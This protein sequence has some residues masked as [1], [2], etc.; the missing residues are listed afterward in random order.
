LV[1]ELRADAFERAHP[2]LQA[3]FSHYALV[4]IHPFADGNGRVARALASIYLYREAS[5]PF[6]LFAD[7]ADSYLAALRAADVGRPQVFVDFV[8]DRAIG[9]M[10]RFGDVIRF[11]DV[12]PAEQ[13]LKAIE[14][15]AYAMPGL[16][17]RQLDEAARRL[18][19]FVRAELQRQA[20]ALPKP[21]T[22]SIIFHELG[23]ARNA[24]AGFRAPIEPTF[25]GVRLQMTNKAP[26]EAAVYRD[27]HI[28]VTTGQQRR[29]SFV[30]QRDKSEETLM[31]GVDDVHPDISLDAQFRIGTFATGQINSILAIVQR[32]AE[33]NRKSRGY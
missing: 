19:G 29:H 12:P 23:A 16:T 27:Y 11:I 17:H 32:E 10:A 3:A 26:A 25:G 4:R 15:L 21:A 7:Q 6:L 20:E 14:E 28:F 1:S 30:V 8:Y 22:L 2:A 18:F 9:A 5:M 13:S 31:L 24:P 33:A